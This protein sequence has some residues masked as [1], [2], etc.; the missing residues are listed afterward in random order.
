MGNACLSGAVNAPKRGEW[1]DIEQPS[2]V[3]FWWYYPRKRGPKPLPPIKGTCLHCG[4]GFEVSRRGNREKKFCN[5]RCA[6]RY[7]MV[8][9]HKGLYER[10][11][12]IEPCLQC[13]DLLPIKSRK[14][15]ELV[16]TTKSYVLHRRRR[17]GFDP[18]RIM[19]ATSKRV[20]EVNRP[21]V[22]R[23]R[24]AKQEAHRMRAALSTAWREEWSGVMDC[25]HGWYVVGRYRNRI[26]GYLWQATKRATDPEWRE[27]ARIRAH[28]NRL[29]QATPRSKRYIP[30]LG[31]TRWQARKHV[32]RQFLPGM[33]WENHG[34][35]W[36]IDHIIPA[37]RFDVRDPLQR[38]QMC[39]YT[40]LQPLWRKDNRRKLD[41][42]ERGTS[43]QLVML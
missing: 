34:T 26:K 18:R 21:A 41:R 23:E 36:E 27:R 11:A 30:E 37:S 3:E 40:N 10:G 2:G 33:S 15:A 32:E 25:W 16:G 4:A 43:L 12:T 29:K 19:S 8:L 13:H 7:N 6:C 1:R 5:E 35:A 17:T 38:L 14:S 31:C 42:V 9:R 20:A 39:H 22:M 28:S 24:Q